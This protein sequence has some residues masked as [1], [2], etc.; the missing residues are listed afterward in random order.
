MKQNRLSRKNIILPVAIVLLLGVGIIGWQLFSLAT[1]SDQ[2]IN[3]VG[4]WP[5]PTPFAQSQIS[6][7]TAA[8]VSAKLKAAGLSDDAYRDAT[9]IRTHQ[10]RLEAS[11]VSPEALLQYAAD[12][13]RLNQV[14]PLQ[15]NS[16]CGIARL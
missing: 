3:Q 2:I 8:G 13:Q 16:M 5:S 14:T 11:E 1:R 12:L 10:E 15:T 6:D 7:N 9:G 4:I